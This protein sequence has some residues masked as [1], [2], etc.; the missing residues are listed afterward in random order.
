MLYIL[1]TN[2]GERLSTDKATPEVSTDIP[3]ASLP[4]AIT[5]ITTTD[6][7]SYLRECLSISGHHV[8][9]HIFVSVLPNVTAPNTP[10]QTLIYVVKSV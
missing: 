9:L 4:T 5:H 7:I 6:Y 2:L 10:N 1:T 3:P 8:V